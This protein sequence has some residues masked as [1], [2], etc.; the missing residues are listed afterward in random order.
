MA[1][2]CTPKIS[3]TR[4]SWFSRTHQITPVAHNHLLLCAA[5][6]NRQGPR[7]NCLIRTPRVAG[8]PYARASSSESSLFLRHDPFCSC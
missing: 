7:H 1:Q 6:A 3:S 5:N 2:G 4:I 8:S